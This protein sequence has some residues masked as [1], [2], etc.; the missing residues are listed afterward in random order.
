M[1]KKLI[2]IIIGWSKR[3]G[4]VETTPAEKKLSDLRMMK[5][6]G[7]EHAKESRVLKIVDGHANYEQVIAC[8]ICKCPC[9]QKT[10]V[11]D[12]TCPINKW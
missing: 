5:C 2:H 6:I 8:S 1:R 9:L 12:E 7:C 3:M 4:W 10:L 11:V